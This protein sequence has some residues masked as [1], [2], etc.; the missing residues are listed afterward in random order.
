M[1][2][3]LLILIALILL[4]GREITLFLLFWLFIS[5]LALCGLIVL[6]AFYKTHPGGTQ[7][8]IA[9]TCLCLFAG[10]VCRNWQRWKKEQQEWEKENWANPPAGTKVAERI[11]IWLFGLILAVLGVVFLLIFLGWAFS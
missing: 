7:S 1:V 6:L 10:L 11:L 5:G 9:I 8:F 3:A 2:T 4:L